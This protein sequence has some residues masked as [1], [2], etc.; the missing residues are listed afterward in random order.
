AA[1]INDVRNTK[2]NLSVSGPG[3][4]KASTETRVCV[5][6][7]T[8]HQAN[9]DIPAPLWNRDLSGATYTLYTSASLDN[10]GLTD[11]DGSS[12][13]CLSCHDG[14]IAIG[15]VNVL[16][17]SF[18]DLD[19]LTEDITMA[20]VGATDKTMTSVPGS[21]ATTGYTRLLGTDLTNDHP[22][23]FTYDTALANADGE[24]RD[25]NN[26]AEVFIGNRQAGV[27]PKPKVPLEN[28]K[29]Q[30]SA[31]HD[32]HIRD[33]TLTYATKFLRLNRFQKVTPAG[34]DF[35]EADDIMCLA[36]HDKL[37]TA[38]SLS[39]HANSA[40]ADEAYKLADSAQ[41]EFPDNIQVWEAACLNCHDSHTVQGARR[42][43]REGTD[44]T[45]KPKAGGNSAIEETCYQCHASS[46]DSIL[47]S[48]TNV[49][50]IKDDF[51]L[52]YRMP[53]TGTEVHDITNAD[54][55]ES[56]TLLGLTPSNRHAE[57][58]DCH[59]PHRVIKNRLFNANP[60]TADLA[61]THSHGTGHTNIASGVLK[62]AYGVDPNSPINY[63][64]DNSFHTTPADFNIKKG[65]GGIGASDLAS[66]TYVTREYQIC[67]K[68]HSTYGYV[69]PPT[70]GYSGGTPYA[71]NG[72]LTYTD[73]AKEFHSPSSHKAE[74]SMGADGGASSAYSTN[75]HRSWHPVVDN[76]GRS[77]TVRDASTG[78]FLAPWNGSGDIGNQT[79][80]CSDCHG[81]NTASGTSTPTGGED[82]NPWG[83]HGSSNTFLLKGAWVATGLS[84]GSGTPDHLC[85]KC[86]NYNDYANQ[87]GST[88]NKSGF[89]G[90]ASMMCG[91]S[92]AGT[93][94]HVGHLGA[95]G[96]MRCKWCHVLVPHG[97][98]NKALLVN[99]ND[100]GPEAGL[101]IGTYKPSPYTKEPYYK[102]AMLQVDTFASSG[103]WSSDSCGG[104]MWMTMNCNGG[105]APN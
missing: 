34:A 29:M 11:P 49:P 98:K 97:W 88:P 90:T 3:T 41:R 73:Q 37:G 43:L 102:D 53:I 40:V 66:N 9:I 68:C 16:N 72:M 1:R 6:C 87:T 48:V 103:N 7:H 86:H 101:A 91:I 69:T 93:N 19:P 18:T 35:V 8:P 45:A 4:V 12:K 56:R 26:V 62:G 23:S 14:T 82:G 104:R 64:T 30:C 81:S 84:T 38:W 65:N 5:F 58:T 99:R 78:V 22:I 75:N 85:F 74:V 105:A 63:Y 94:L 46:V 59:N 77:V 33:D 57:C 76:T 13:L 61:G 20:G 92:Y 28:N 42:L 24:L 15:A 80:Y 67:L 71:T 52:T 31:C 70:L 47:T 79:M 36:C 44:S 2:H 89:N 50:N 83:P 21:G 39:A 54:L 60:V 55:E 25:P 51:L 10:T 32:P 95:V 17:G 100:I 96:N 27:Q